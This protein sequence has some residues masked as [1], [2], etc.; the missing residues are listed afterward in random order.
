MQNHCQR[1]GHRIPLSP[2]K[3]LLNMSSG[4]MPSSW[5]AGSLNTTK[6][7]EHY[8]RDIE[9]R[10]SPSQHTL[11]EFHHSREIFNILSSSGEAEPQLLRTTE[12]CSTTEKAGSLGSHY[13]SK[14][15]SFIHHSNTAPEETPQLRLVEGLLQRLSV[16]TENN[17]IAEKR[18]TGLRRKTVY[19]ETLNDA[20]SHIF[21]LQT[22][23]KDLTPEVAQDYDAL[24]EQIQDRVQKLMKAWL[25]DCDDDA[26][27][28]LTHA[29][30]HILDAD[31]LARFL[32]KYPDLIDGLNFPE[33]DEDIV[34]SVI[35]RHLHV[36]VFQSFLY[37][38]I[39]HSI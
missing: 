26:H 37:D 30:R 6:T 28:F 29:K 13:D 16:P 9:V 22:Y 19:S 3:E 12:P 36:R 31:R 8:E 38:A 15:V 10:N 17:Q 7:H 23:R 32:K 4:V 34:T 25:E 14:T 27:A 5:D 20:Q 2:E 18:Q 35:M 21:S 1:E 33:T 39:P 24:I 11:E